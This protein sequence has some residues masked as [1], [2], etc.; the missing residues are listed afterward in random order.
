MKYTIINYKDG[1]YY[2]KNDE[3]TTIIVSEKV[4]KT[5]FWQVMLGVYVEK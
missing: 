4:L 1:K 2:L 3:S 5:C